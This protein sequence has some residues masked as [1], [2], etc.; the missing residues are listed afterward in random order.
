[1]AVIHLDTEQKS[2]VHSFYGNKVIVNFGNEI[3]LILTTKQLKQLQQGIE[4]FM[5]AQQLASQ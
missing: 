1:M 5:K 3:D 2:Y 4:D